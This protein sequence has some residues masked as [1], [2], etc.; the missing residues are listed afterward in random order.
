[1]PRR[2]FI[3]VDLQND[4]TN[5]QGSL[6]V[7]DGEGGARVP[8]AI[9]KH[10][11]SEKYDLVVFT[12]DA[13]PDG[14]ISFASRFDAK[15]FTF[16]E[17]KKQMMWPD[18]CKPGYWGYRFD[19]DI[20]LNHVNIIVCKGQDK[21]FD[22][23]SGIKDDNGKL[24]GLHRLLDKDDDVVIAGY[25]FDYCVK[26]T[27]IDVKEYVDNVTVLKELCP[28]VDPSKDGETVAE[29]EKN[30]VRVA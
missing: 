7:D 1:M 28:S 17:E 22:S 18:H 10:L 14:H 30:G 16:N 2:I 8:K 25:C 6:F 21:D 26:A 29:L 15:P 20:D 4:F 23:Y 3:G 5:Q 19:D 9:N 24:T 11:E 13:H 27:A 12:A